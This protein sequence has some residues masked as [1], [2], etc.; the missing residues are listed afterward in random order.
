MPTS[1][2]RDIHDV[3]SRISTRGPRS[4]RPAS[5]ATAAKPASTSTGAAHEA[6]VTADERSN[7]AASIATTYQPAPSPPRAKLSTAGH[8]QRTCRWAGSISMRCAV[9]AVA[10][11]QS[12]R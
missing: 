5:P 10:I 1:S 9:I 4:G 3:R 7:P 2:S 11:A 8:P 12:A 6:A